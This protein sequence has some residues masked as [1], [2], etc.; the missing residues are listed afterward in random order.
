MIQNIDESNDR[1]F[2]NGLINCLEVFSC[3]P[4]I[5][6]ILVYECKTYFDIY[7]IITALEA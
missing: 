5:L 2:L 6:I 7:K 3:N 4:L 1:S